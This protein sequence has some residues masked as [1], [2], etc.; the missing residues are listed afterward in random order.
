VFI[1][2]FLEAHHEL[3]FGQRVAASREHAGAMPKRT[4]RG[5]I[6]RVAGVEDLP[7]LVVRVEAAEIDAKR[8][9]EQLP[10]LPRGIP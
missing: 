1:N 3:D 2:R 6:H 8:L 9:F 7:E 4:E 5:S 10:E